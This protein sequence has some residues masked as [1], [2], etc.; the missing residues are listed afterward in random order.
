MSTDKG[1]VKVYRDVRDHWVWKDKPFSRGQAW[2]DLLMMVNHEDK[3]ILFDG[4]LIPVNR[5]MTITSLHKLAD[6]W[7]WS[8]SKVGRFLDILEQD[9]MIR[10]ERN[11]KRTA[12]SIVNYSDYQDTRNTERNTEKT[13]K[14]R[15]KNADETKQDTI[16]DTIEDTKEEYIAPDGA[17][18][19]ETDGWTDNE[20]WGFD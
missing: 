4:V 11:T 3:K 2:I 1:Y 19:T 8:T 20:G 7:G 15:R 14:K 16:E 13:Q 18:S 6:R 9:V 17:D 5:G 12:I 10:Q